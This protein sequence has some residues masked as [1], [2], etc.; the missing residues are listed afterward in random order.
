MCGTWHPGC[1]AFNQSS[2]GVEMDTHIHSIVVPTDFS[3]PSEQAVE[4]AGVLATS[5][6]ATV[7]LVHVLD[8]LLSPEMAWAA[9]ATEAAALR[10]RLYQEGRAKLA[11]LAATVRESGVPV[12]TEVRSGLPSQEIIHAAV[13]YGADLIVMTTRGR[14][15]LSHLLLGSVAEDVIRHARCPVL[16]LPLRHAQRTSPSLTETPSAHAA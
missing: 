15:G 4:Y 3:T 11:A 8:R 14:T 16:A 6:G 2:H 13:D 9:P 10:E 7:H 5:L 1:F 12:T